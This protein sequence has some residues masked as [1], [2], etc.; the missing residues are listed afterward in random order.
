MSAA[1]DQISLEAARQI[2]ALGI[3][4]PTQRQA[5]IQTIVG[6]AITNVI[7]E[8]AAA[9]LRALHGEDRWNTD[10][11]EQDIRNWIA[12]LEAYDGRPMVTLEVTP[13]DRAVL[14]SLLRAVQP[15]GRE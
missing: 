7:V 8:N 5:A 4:N 15:Q 11:V 3:D 2:Q 9:V 6:S 14:L 13:H 12:R 10:D 1:K